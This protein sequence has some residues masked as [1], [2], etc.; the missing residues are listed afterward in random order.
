MDMGTVPPLLKLV[1]D[2]AGLTVESVDWTESGM[3]GL[4]RGMVDVTVR[5]REGLWKVWVTT[6]VYPLGTEVA[7]DEAVPVNV[8]IKKFQCI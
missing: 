1:P 6:V 8:P 3:L 4:P 2:V 7:M 5:V